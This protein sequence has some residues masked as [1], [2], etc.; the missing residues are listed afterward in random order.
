MDEL[1]RKADE[2]LIDSL[3]R[4]VKDAL[5]EALA[6]GV[7]QGAILEIIGFNGGNSLRYAAMWA[8]IEAKG[9]KANG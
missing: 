9:G 2:V 1:R 8:Y 5:D 6:K 7:S 4:D 3:P